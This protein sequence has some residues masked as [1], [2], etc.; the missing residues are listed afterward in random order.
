MRIFT[1]AIAVLALVIT[2]GAMA[3]QPSTAGKAETLSSAPGNSFTVTNYYKQNVYDK[4]DQRIGQIADVLMTED[5][6]ITAFVIGAGG[7]LGMGKHDVLV[8]FSAVSTTKK[9]GKTYLVMDTSKDALKSAPGFK[10]DRTAR[11]WVR[12]DRATEGS[13]P[14]GDKRSKKQ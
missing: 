5:G 6:K 3:Q 9:D 11:T 8:P 10:Y 4:A 13:R 1:P 2:S 14:A 12:E 7:F